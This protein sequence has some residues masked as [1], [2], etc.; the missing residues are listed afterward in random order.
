MVGRCVLPAVS[1]RFPLLQRERGWPPIEAGEQQHTCC[2]RRL[3]S[4][5]QMQQILRPGPATPG[6]GHRGRSV[7][8]CLHNLPACISS[9]NQFN[10]M[11][12]YCVLEKT[13]S[14]AISSLLLL[15]SQI[16]GEAAI[17]G[18][19][20]NR[21][22]ISDRQFCRHGRKVSAQQLTVVTLNTSSIL[23]RNVS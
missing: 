16:C 1:C 9:H 23:N 20:N 19:L 18:G 5:E 17:H 4:V 21:E 8:P 6:S 7:L 14:L 10:M 22:F 3:P 12:L 15:E 13:P 2:S 11:E